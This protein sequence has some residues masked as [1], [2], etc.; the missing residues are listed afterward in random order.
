MVDTE[1]SAENMTD[2]SLDSGD[3]P[4][5]WLFSGFTLL[6]FFGILAI[7]IFLHHSL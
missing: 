1:H 6:I 7:L 3:E 5:G 2:H 4:A